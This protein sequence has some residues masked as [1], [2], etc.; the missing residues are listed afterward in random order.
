MFNGDGFSTVFAGVCSQLS[1]IETVSGCLLKLKWRRRFPERGPTRLS[2]GK[3]LNCGVLG[4]GLRKQARN[5]RGTLLRSVYLKRSG[6]AGAAAEG[7]FN[8]AFFSLNKE[9][10]FSLL[11]TTHGS[12]ST[13]IS[14]W[15]RSA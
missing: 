9:T 15:P 7:I 3:A 2:F 13:W 14:E 5:P 12:S 1:N 10:P 6:M 8:G 4:D 11:K